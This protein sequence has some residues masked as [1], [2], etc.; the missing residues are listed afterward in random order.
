MPWERL[1][2]LSAPSE[3]ASP[4]PQS[5][6][7]FVGTPEGRH[8]LRVTVQ[9]LDPLATLKEGL[10]EE[11]VF[12]PAHQELWFA[13][14]C[15]PPPMDTLSFL[16]LRVKNLSVFQIRNSKDLGVRVRK[17][18]SFGDAEEPLPSQRMPQIQPL[19]K[20][21]M[22]E[23]EEEEEEEDSPPPKPTPLRQS[24]SSSSQSS[25]PSSSRPST[26][27]SAAPSTLQQ[28]PIVFSASSPRAGNSSTSHER[29][30][31]ST[32]LHGMLEELDAALLDSGVRSTSDHAPSLPQHGN[33]RDWSSLRR[34]HLQEQY[35]QG[36]ELEV[37]IVPCA[38]LIG[39][40]FDAFQLRVREGN[41]VRTLRRLI[42]AHL[43]SRAVNTK[44]R[45]RT[46]DCS[47][48]L[49]MFPHPFFPMK[50]LD[51]PL[52]DFGVKHRSKIFLGSA[53]FQRPSI[54]RAVN[55]Q[56]H[57][58]AG[59]EFDLSCRPAQT[60]RSLKS[61]LFQTFP[62]LREDPPLYIL[63]FGHLVELEDNLLLEDY[64]VEAGDIVYVGKQSAGH[65]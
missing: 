58:P 13:G 52:Y 20:E 44:E 64:L 63:S 40:H 18:L 21:H 14:A 25:T 28:T 62:S 29:G 22:E 26:P 34:G 24:S 16:N 59:E 4:L 23:E 8:S 1:P 61:T 55:I 3:A 45:M 46:I 60:V 19:V 54:E 56:I 15:I 49:L 32:S 47:D 7:L 43:L 39:Q 9:E 50:D 57:G 51:A 12:D 11:G 27:S 42:F 10:Q 6:L 53:C 31:A 17:E 30:Q 5:L 48:Q 33:P 65:R 41:T 35:N 38:R 2:P 37:Q 36:E